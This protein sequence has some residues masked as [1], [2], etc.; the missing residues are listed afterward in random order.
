MVI[1]AE[2]TH[3]E[4][5]DSISAEVLTSMTHQTFCVFV[6]KKIYRGTEH[7]Y[8]Q[9][10]RRYRYWDVSVFQKHHGHSFRVS[11][12]ALNPNWGVSGS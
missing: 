7:K 4:V 8:T 5:F 3:S 2:L 11:D 10:E 6:P 9:Q 12:S 1:A